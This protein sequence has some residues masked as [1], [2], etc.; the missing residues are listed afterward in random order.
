MKRGALEGAF[1]LTKQYDAFRDNPWPLLYRE[2]DIRHPGSKFILTTRMT[3]RWI[4]SVVDHFGV[5]NTEMREWIY[6]VGHPA[7]NEDRYVSVY[8]AHNAAV[9][10]YFAGQSQ[11]L[12]VSWE[13]GHGWP[14]LA[15]FLGTSVPAIAFPKANTKAARGV[16]A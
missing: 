12:D 4:S 15:V 10:Q 9:R 8:E 16:K 1:S 7:G 6:G 5:S 2:C 14:E 3:A 11:L 13:E